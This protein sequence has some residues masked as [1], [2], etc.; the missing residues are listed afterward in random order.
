MTRKQQREEIAALRALLGLSRRRT[1]QEWEQLPQDVR[2]GLA[3]RAFV[4]EWGDLTAALIRLGFPALNKLPPNEA[5]RYLDHIA[6]IFGAPGVQAIL[7]R[8]LAAIDDERKSIV[9]R[10]TKIAL[11]GEDA[12]S[13]RAAALLVKVCRWVFC[14]VPA[15]S[16]AA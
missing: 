5:R 11:Y 6:R 16:D 15:P 3:A 9:A 10:Q 13:V 14:A 1:I 8:D 7:A 2:D 12:E 4:A